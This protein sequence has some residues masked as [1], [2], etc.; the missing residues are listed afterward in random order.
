[1]DR[2]TEKRSVWTSQR[3]KSAWKNGQDMTA[4]DRMARDTKA[5]T[6]EL[7]DKSAGIGQPAQERKR[8]QLGK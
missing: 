7:G 4:E 1:L 8:V 6:R 2:T 3:D 5:G